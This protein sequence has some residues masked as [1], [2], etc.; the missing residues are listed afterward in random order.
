[1]LS[2]LPIQSV[3]ATRNAAEARKVVT[4]S[5][6]SAVPTPKRVMTNPVRNACTT[7]DTTFV[8]ANTRERCAPIAG[9]S[10]YDDTGLV[11][12]KSITVDTIS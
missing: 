10:K 11:N 7:S 2:R 9:P 4:G 3:G 6:S 1:M 5:T 12:W 8:I